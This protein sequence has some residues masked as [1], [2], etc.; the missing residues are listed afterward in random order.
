MFLSQLLQWREFNYFMFWN[1]MCLS[2]ESFN[3]HSSGSFWLSVFDF[4]CFSVTLYH[5]SYSGSFVVLVILFWVSYIPCLAS[6]LSDSLLCVWP[7]CLSVCLCLYMLWVIVSCFPPHVSFSSPLPVM[8]LMSP[9]VPSLPLIYLSS[10]SLSNSCVSLAF[11]MCLLFPC[12]CTLCLP[13]SL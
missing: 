6:W 3:C 12:H 13:L 1:K 2:S 9:L 7:L 10:T 8:F 11:L 5:S 4:L